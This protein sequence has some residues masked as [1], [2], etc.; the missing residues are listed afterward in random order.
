VNWQQHFLMVILILACAVAQTTL[1]VLLW[2]GAQPDL[3]LA[4]V[5]LAGLYLGP[6]AGSLYAFGMGYISDLLTGGVVGI[7][8]FDRVVIYVLANRMSHLFYAKSAAAQFIV[9]VLL[10]IV[11][12]L[13]V[14]L[15]SLIFGQGLVIRETQAL[16]LPIRAIVTALAGMPLY[17]IIKWIEQMGK[18]KPP[19]RTLQKK[20]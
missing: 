11:D 13:I 15:L 19:P 10:S 16:Y 6:V 4:V 5:V 17:F 2:K 18:P 1:T 14:L 9:I 3:L 20:T 12:T 7:F 8:M